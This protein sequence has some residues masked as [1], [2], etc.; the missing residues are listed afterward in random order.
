MFVGRTLLS[1]AACS[2]SDCSSDQDSNLEVLHLAHAD[3][4]R[5]LREK[6]KVAKNLEFLHLDHADPAEVARAK[7]K[8]QKKSSSFCTS[9]APIPTEGRF[10]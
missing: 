2:L 3:P 4:R 5:G 9:T 6:N 10:S 8:S 7:T 1:L